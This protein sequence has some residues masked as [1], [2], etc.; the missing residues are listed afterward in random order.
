M[1]S[2][3]PVRPPLALFVAV[4]GLIV[5]ALG[6]AAAGLTGRFDH[7]LGLRY[8]GVFMGLLMIISGNA[9]PKLSQPHTAGAAR[10]ADRLAGWLFV[11]GGLAVVAQWIWWAEA[12]R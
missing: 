11:L 2:S 12:S 9:L 5:M 8:F 7:A 4:G 6:G 1:T 10:T 3:S